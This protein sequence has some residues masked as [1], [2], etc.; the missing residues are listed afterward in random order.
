MT[1][2]KGFF[3]ASLASSA[4]LASPIY[5]TPLPQNPTADVR[6]QAADPMDVGN[7]LSGTY[8]FTKSRAYFPKQGEVQNAHPP[9]VPGVDWSGYDFTVDYGAAN[10]EFD[11]KGGVSLSA[12][13]TDLTGARIS[14]TRYMLYG[15]VTIPIKPITNRGV[16]TTFITMSH[17]QDEID[18]ELFTKNP[19]KAA[20]SNLFY[21]GNREDHS[22]GGEH[23]PDS[24]TIDG[25]NE[26]TID[27]THDAIKW[28]I[29]GKTVREYKREENP[30]AFPNTPSVV[31]M[32]V[33]TVDSPDVAQGTRDW[34]GGPT[35]WGNNDLLTAQ[36][37]PMKVQ[38]YDNN[39]RAVDMWPIQGN[40]NQT[41]A[42]TVP[43]TTAAA[44]TTTVSTT[45]VLETVAVQPIKPYTLSVS[46]KAAA[47]AFEVS[48]TQTPV[49]G[50]RTQT[51]TN[52]VRSMGAAILVSFAAVIVSF[53]AAELF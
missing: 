1:G 6:S 3:L 5:A 49:P 50:T 34:A 39:D 2:S 48:V 29:N 42:T 16:I 9:M 40:R 25:W 22:R 30:T 31:Q 27:W 52:G 8:E 21:R 26:Y 47:P 19:A 32:A 20:T 17:V 53:A 45:L 38:C 10:A 14:T 11:D 7:C 37:G 4:L 36:Y 44:S 18:W 43:T 23:S 41:T 35:D 15:R 28:I 46:S 33:W 13:K 24:G 51:S 12:R